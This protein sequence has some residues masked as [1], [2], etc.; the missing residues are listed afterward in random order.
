MSAWCNSS[1]HDFAT[2]QTLENKMVSDGGPNL[3]LTDVIHSFGLFVR[4]HVAVSGG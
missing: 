4:S 3:S 2:S 1:A